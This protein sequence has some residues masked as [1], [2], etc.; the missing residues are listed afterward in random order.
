MSVRTTPR[1]AAVGA[2]A[3]VAALIAVAAP[4]GTAAPADAAPASAAP[5]NAS[6]TS[7]PSGTLSL[8]TL[9][10]GCTTSDGTIRLSDGR[11]FAIPARGVSVVALSVAA[12]G[13]AAPPEVVVANTGR[14]G[15]AVR[16]GDAWQ[17]AP[18]AVR[19]QQSAA[20]A[21]GSA[22]TTG[23]KAPASTKCT[24]TANKQNDYRWSS[25]VQWYY[26]GTGSK[27]TYAQSA[28]QKAANAWTGK[29]SSC[30]KTVTSTAAN[31][32]VR[33]A[34][35]APNVTAKGGCSASSGYSVTGWGALPAGTL[36]VTCVWYDQDGVV[37]EADQRYSTKYAWS[38]TASCS[39]NRFDV[40]AVAT[41]EWGHLYG[42]G[43]VASGTGQVMEAAEG[44]CALGSRT[45][46]FGDMTGIAAKY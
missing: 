8:S 46:G 13:A 2:S 35:Q 33:A 36:G 20:S 21:T 1:T 31:T 24:S 15:V 45:L 30:G 7:C 40:Q 25:T 37:K 4:A 17:G 12:P 41:H 28:L 19:Q 32:Y 34:A 42:L 18:T 3:A 26:N 22:A 44:P 5:A 43:H 9:R 11:T 23:T 10:S 29:I 39:G 38:S 6:G 14:A 16:V 27:G